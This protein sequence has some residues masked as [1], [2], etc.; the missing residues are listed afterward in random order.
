MSKVMRRRSYLLDEAVIRQLNE[1]CFQTKRRPS[2]VIE[3]AVKEFFRHAGAGRGQE[4]GQ[5]R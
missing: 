3:E 2:H 4:A 1:F 5:G